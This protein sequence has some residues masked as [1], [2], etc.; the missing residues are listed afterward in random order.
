MG[1]EESDPRGTVDQLGV[2]VVEVFACVSR[3][4]K[5]LNAHSDTVQKE[6]TQYRRVKCLGTIR[7]IRDSSTQDV[8]EDQRNHNL[9]QATT[10]ITLALPL[11]GLQASR[12]ALPSTRGIYLTVAH[13]GRAEDLDQ[14]EHD[15]HAD[16]QPDVGG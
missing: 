1:P 7:A 8:A 4:L 5:S 14:D 6:T 15:K 12:T 11:L 2:D 16:A 9:S 3:K 13:E 10:A